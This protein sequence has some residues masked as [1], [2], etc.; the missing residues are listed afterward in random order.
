MSL[1][2]GI[3]ENTCEG[4]KGSIIIEPEQII[5][6]ADYKCGKYFYLEPILNTFKREIIKN[7]VA[8]R[9]KVRKKVH[10]VVN[11]KNCPG[12]PI[13]YTTLVMEP[14]IFFKLKCFSVIFWAYF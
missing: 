6:K 1:L 12:E 9:K 7:V 10:V 4:Y 3:I 14:D 2:S 5:A 13:L 11:M 8:N